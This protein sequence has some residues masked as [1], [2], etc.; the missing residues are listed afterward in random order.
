MYRLDVSEPAEK[1]LL[2]IVKY[3]AFRLSLLM[4]A[5]QMMEIFEEAILSLA[6]STERC[7]LIA[8]KPLAHLKYRKLMVKNYIILSINEKERVVDIERI[9]YARRSWKRFI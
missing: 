5:A 7:T 8:D 4:S 9:L 1:D 6:E 3:I 2:D